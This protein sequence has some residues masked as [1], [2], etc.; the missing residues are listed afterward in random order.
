MIVIFGR[1]FRCTAEV[2]FTRVFSLSTSPTP[3]LDHIDQI[4]GTGEGCTL[5]QIHRKKD[6][7]ID[8]FSVMSTSYHHLTKSTLSHRSDSLSLM[9]RS[10]FTQCVVLLDAHIA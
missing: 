4:G 1:L 5:I 2:D 3:L 10:M 8:R 6:R 7:P 9:C